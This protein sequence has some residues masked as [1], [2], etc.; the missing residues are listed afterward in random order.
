MNENSTI[1][2]KHLKDNKEERNK[3]FV[4]K[5]LYGQSCYYIINARWDKFVLK[6][7]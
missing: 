4:L 6:E 7:N 1:I 5:K 2:E 3:L